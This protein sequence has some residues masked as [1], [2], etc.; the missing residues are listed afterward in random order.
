M[1]LLSDQTALSKIYRVDEEDADKVQL[2]QSPPS[3]YLICPKKWQRRKVEPPLFFFLSSLLLLHLSSLFFPAVLWRRWPSCFRL[4]EQQN[5]SFP[6]QSIC[7]R[8]P[9]APLD[10]M[11]PSCTSAGHFVCQFHRVQCRST[12]CILKRME[13]DVE[14]TMHLKT[15]SNGLWSSRPA[16]APQRFSPCRR[17]VESCKF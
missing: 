16:G 2:K 14:L 6:L 12:V 15:W 13:E 11:S 4:S 1:A 5:P 10:L 8:H 9:F 7:R 3:F 17:K